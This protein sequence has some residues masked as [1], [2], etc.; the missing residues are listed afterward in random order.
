[1]NR[2]F[3]TKT[4][5]VFENLTLPLR[6]LPSPTRQFA[7]A[8]AY[9]RKVIAS[10]APPNQ[11]ALAYCWLFHLVGDLHQPL[12]STA[13]VCERFPN[14]DRGGNS[15]PTVQGRNLHAL[16]DGLLGRQH[17]PN[18]VQREVAELEQRP[19]LWKLDTKCGVEAWI[20]ESHEL[21]KT[22]AYDPIILKAVEQPGEL[23]PIN[24]PEPYL[25]AAGEK[26]RQR[27]VAAGLRLAS[28]SN[29]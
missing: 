25:K 12:H 15:I 13:L 17:R 1:V 24:L 9:C 5:I 4:C 2:K 6:G 18:D 20:Q 22:F 21:A 8:V 29:Q 27:I 26:A 23:R 19:A 16:W 7:Q 14:G 3:C 10:D 11:K 28:L